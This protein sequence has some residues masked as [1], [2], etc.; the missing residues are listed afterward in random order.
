MVKALITFYETE[1]QEMIDFIC[2]DK[3]DNEITFYSDECK[4]LISG[5]VDTTK[6]MVKIII[7]DG[8]T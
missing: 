7:E 5:V 8:S 6:A 2:L 1:H 3:R 4:N